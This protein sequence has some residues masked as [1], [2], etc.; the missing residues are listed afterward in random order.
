MKNRIKKVFNILFIAIIVAAIIVNITIKVL[1]KT[2]G[3]GS[4]YLY[5]FVAS[6]KFM[7]TTQNMNI[8]DFSGGRIYYENNLENRNIKLIDESIQKGVNDSNKYFGQAKLYPLKIVVFSTTEEYKKA[9]INVQLSEGHYD[10]YAIY[11]SLED[12][13]PY[14]LI[15][16]YTHFKMESFCRDKGIAFLAIPAWFDEGIAEY[17]SFQ[18]RRDKA[19]I[20]SLNKLIDFRELRAHPGFQKANNEGYNVYFQSYLGIKKI[21][22]LK[23]EKCLQNILLD[24]KKMDFDSAF[25]KNTGISIEELQKLLK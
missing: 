4:Y 8:Q 16:E 7:A 6:T 14:K 12:I 9:F 1:M 21:V 24:S 25:V 18:Y 22:E 2:E 19:D 17:I 15:H 11:L 13:T 3:M 10:T 23:D 20:V 5:R